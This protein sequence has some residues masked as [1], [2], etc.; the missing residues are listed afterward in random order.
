MT[1]P[2]GESTCDTNRPYTLWTRI[3]RLRWF[4]YGL[5]KYRMMQCTGYFKWKGR[6]MKGPIPEPSPILRRRP[7]WV[8]TP[9]FK[10][11][12]ILGDVEHRIKLL[13]GW[14]LLGAHVALGAL[15]QQIVP[16][17]KKMTEIRVTVNGEQKIWLVSKGM[18]ERI[19]RS[20]NGIR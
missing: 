2:C 8:W 13:T 6:Y 18:M 14:Y 4:T 5:I 10:L 15:R 16:P 11:R 20:V 7:H 17:I 3:L 12:G 1:N 9:W 19:A